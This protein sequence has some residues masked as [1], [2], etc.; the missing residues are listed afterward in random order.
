MGEGII[1]AT[2]TKWLVEPGQKINEDDIIVEIATDKVDSEIPSPVAGTITEL[3]YNEG[4]SPQVGKA[5]ALIEVEGAP[6]EPS[7]VTDE[8]IEQAQQEHSITNENTT[9][10]QST[11]N[12]SDIKDNHQV[13]AFIRTYASDRGVSY[14]E[15]IK[16]IPAD[17]NNGL[18]K[19]DIDEY[20]KNGREFNQITEP[21]KPVMPS[22][23]SAKA[24]EIFSKPVNI[25]SEG[26]F[27]VVE[28][29]RMRKLIA[30]HM[31]TSKKV[32]PHVT[33]F[34]EADVT[35]LVQW[36]EQHKAAFIKKYNERI[37]YTT[38][39]VKAVAEA[40]KKYPDINVSVSG[41]KIFRK[42]E[43]N[44][45]IA[46]ALTDGN[47]IVP[48]IK[49]ADTQNLYGLAKAVNDLT[50]RARNNTLKPTE[51]NN[52]TFTITNLGNFDNIAGTPIINQPEVAI[53]AI[54]AIKRKP[55]VVN[56]VHGETLG[57]RS[58]VILSLSYD[59]RVVDGALGGMFLKQVSLNLEQFN[60]A[61][62]I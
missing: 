28:M 17:K 53:L 40:L 45:G 42:K 47:L 50:Y 21:N 44:V 39:I 46:T 30:D 26:N 7:E 4:D 51:I 18:S 31:V 34:I 61:T 36:R 2:I 5:I 8:T 12:T 23:Y 13:S 9:D 27:E 15:L 35:E 54:G 16:I 56:T 29:D 43:I 19:T 59:H 3:I 38:L 1:E 10:H 60:T 6:D 24:P 41:D 11:A 52:G 58:L 22:K 14:P 49:N 33:S 48:V 55:A 32:A 20:I 62:N 37:T 57:I 25:T